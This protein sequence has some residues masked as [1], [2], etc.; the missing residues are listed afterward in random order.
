MDDVIV[1]LLI[2]HVN[3]EDYSYVFKSDTFVISINKVHAA[4]LIEDAIYYT[5]NELKLLIDAVATGRTELAEG[6]DKYSLIDT[7]DEYE[8]VKSTGVPTHFIT[9]FVLS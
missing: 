2:K 5:R 3:Y 6:S 7:D 9:R 8:L 1:E 4:L